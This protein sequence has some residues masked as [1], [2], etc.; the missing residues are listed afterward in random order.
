[1]KTNKKYSYLKTN[2]KSL[3]IVVLILISLLITGL[4]VRYPAVYA[5]VGY[6]LSFVYD[7]LKHKWQ[8]KLP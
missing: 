2:T 3:K 6:M 1:M 7:W 5:I 8:V 4:E